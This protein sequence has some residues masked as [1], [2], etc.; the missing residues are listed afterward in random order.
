MAVLPKALLLA[1][2][3]SGMRHWAQTRN[4]EAFNVFQIPGSTLCVAPE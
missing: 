4:L 2:G 3:H 1:L